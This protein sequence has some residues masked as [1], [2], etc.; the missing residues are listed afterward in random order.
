MSCPE[1]SRNPTKTSLESVDKTI[2]TPPQ[3]YRFFEQFE[4]KGN[5]FIEQLFD[6]IEPE[7]LEADKVKAADLQ[8][9]DTLVYGGGLAY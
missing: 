3:T 6:T 4:A 5:V 9:Y 8:K 2:G 1:L 7:L